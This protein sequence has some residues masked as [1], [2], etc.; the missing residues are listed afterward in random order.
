MDSALSPKSGKKKFGEVMVEAGIV[1]AEELPR[2][3]EISQRASDQDIEYAAQAKR[4]MDEEGLSA[5]IAVKALL[6]A[7]T[8]RVSLNQALVELGWRSRRPPGFGSSTATPSQGYA[9]PELDALM[10]ARLGNFQEAT[11]DPAMPQQPAVS[12][13]PAPDVVAEAQALTLDMGESQAETMDLGAAPGWQQEVARLNEEAATAG[14]ESQSLFAGAPG[15]G[16]PV[17]ESA[18][19]QHMQ[20]WP[21][22]QTQSAPVG[23]PEPAPT[24]EPAFDA[25]QLAIIRAIEELVMLEAAHGADAPEVAAKCVQVGDLHMAKRSFEAA[26]EQF[27]RAQAILSKLRGDEHL[28]VVAVSARLAEAYMLQ[29]RLQ[30]AAELLAHVLDVRERELGAESL[31]VAQTVES[32][33]A[34]QYAMG[35]YKEAGRLFQ[36]A[37]TRKEKCLSADDP[38][39]VPTLEG[40]AN[41]FMAQERFAEAEL[42]WVRALELKRKKLGLQHPDLAT[43]CCGVGDAFFKLKQVHKALGQY[44]D[45][46]SLAGRSDEPDFVYISS[47]LEKAALC[48]VE[49]RE[50]PE[51]CRYYA[52]MVEGRKRSSTLNMPDMPAILRRYSD[53]LNCC[54]DEETAKQMLA[55]SN[56][57]E[58]G[59]R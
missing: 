29:M 20:V 41:C 51:A 22:G 46:V 48:F 38:E 23:E 21:G 6:L 31:S 40:R 36:Q 16:R 52:K 10:R 27:N 8:R 24:A 47:L 25:R 59:C 57:I 39:L 17:W 13:L 9:R 3:L 12:P 7:R 5:Q 49:L 42:L 37:L 45:A 19:P 26:E 56:E 18:T 30:Q 58:A 53:L 14:Q 28:D 1:T 4:L 11:P 43:T 50:L 35:N 32:L 34:V 2:G 55:L 33:A 54:G 44:E 15:T